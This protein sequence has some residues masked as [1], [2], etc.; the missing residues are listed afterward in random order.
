MK[1]RNRKNR[2]KNAL[3]Y[4]EKQFKSGKKTQ[5][6]TLNKKVN[7]TEKDKK[8]IEKEIEILDKKLNG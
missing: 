3:D 4:L 6:K 1:K 7:L 8:R 5:K 2:Q